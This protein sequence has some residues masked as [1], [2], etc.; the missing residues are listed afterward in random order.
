MDKPGLAV[1]QN[2]QVEVSMLIV[3]G[4][5]HMQSGSESSAIVSA[6]L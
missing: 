1:G 5:G 3:V 4:R 2:W 6:S